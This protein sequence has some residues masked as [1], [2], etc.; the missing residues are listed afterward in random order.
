MKDKFII[1]LNTLIKH[2]LV[3]CLIYLHENK[4]WNICGLNLF[5]RTFPISDLNQCVNT[6]YCSEC[7]SWGHHTLFLIGSLTYLEDCFYIG[8]IKIVPYFSHGCT[9]FRDLLYKVIIQDPDRRN[10]VCWAEK[11]PERKE[12][13]TLIS[14]GLW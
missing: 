4:R 1:K 11:Y 14:F 7:T 6:E 5:S 2:K 13:D 12:S 10:A 8:K 9:T 3:F